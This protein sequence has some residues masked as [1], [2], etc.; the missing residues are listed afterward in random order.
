MLIPSLML[1]TPFTTEMAALGLGVFTW[2][3]D[4]KLSFFYSF[5]KISKDI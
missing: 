4:Q 2:Q 3:S 5:E 1:M